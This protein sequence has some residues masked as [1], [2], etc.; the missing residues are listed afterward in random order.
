MLIVKGRCWSRRRTRRYQVVVEVDRVGK[1]G[2][3]GN[4][5]TGN[6]IFFKQ[7]IKAVIVN[8]QILIMVLGDVA[9]AG[10]CDPTVERR[11]VRE[12]DSDKTAARA[13]EN[14]EVWLGGLGRSPE[15]RDASKRGSEGVMREVR[16]LAPRSL[17][18]FW[19]RPPCMQ[20]VIPACLTAS[21]AGQYAEV[22]TARP[23]EQSSSDWWTV[24]CNLMKLVVKSSNSHDQLCR[25]QRKNSNFHSKAYPATTSGMKEDFLPGRNCI[26]TPKS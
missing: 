13:M 24:L 1:E 15:Y 14:V 25:Q 2:F 6:N 5:T 3:L 7:S 26:F 8:Y 17:F 12:I 19:V 18:I 21:P 22:I 20:L 10:L 16:S 9:E 4:K 23:S 11:E